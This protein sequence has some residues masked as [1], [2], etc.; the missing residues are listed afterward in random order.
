MQVFLDQYVVTLGLQYHLNQNAS[1]RVCP[2]IGGTKFL[3][4][5][6]CLFVLCSRYRELLLRIFE[7]NTYDMC[8][9]SND[10][11]PTPSATT[12]PCEMSLSLNHEAAPE[13]N[14][15]DTRQN[16]PVEDV[17]S[18]LPPSFTSLL[19]N[20][21]PSFEQGRPYHPMF[22]TQFHSQLPLSV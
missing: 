4:L 5:L 14:L 11:N 18:D 1:L 7:P 15:Q 8:R 9:P 13:K 16:N 19:M 21:G 12:Y 2:H 22:V 20:C 17:L 3:L 6:D 10:W